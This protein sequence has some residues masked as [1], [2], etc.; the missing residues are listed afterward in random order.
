MVLEFLSV[1]QCPSQAINVVRNP[2][3]VI[4][5]YWRAVSNQTVRLRLGLEF[6]SVFQGP[7]QANVR[8]PQEV[9]VIGERVRI[10]LRLRLYHGHLSALEHTKES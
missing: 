5:C 8:N 3:D 4:K 1:F 6:L 7:S 9:S 2:Q 10:K